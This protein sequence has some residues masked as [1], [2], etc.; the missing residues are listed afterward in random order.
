MIDFIFHM[1]VCVIAVTAFALLADIVCFY[2]RMRW[3]YKW[4]FWTRVSAISLAVLLIAS[5][6]NLGCVAYLVFSA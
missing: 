5:M 3:G 4:K 6:V 2:N 1:T